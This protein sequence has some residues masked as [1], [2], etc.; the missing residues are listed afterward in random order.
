MNPQTL[1]LIV[2]LLQLGEKAFSQV[3]DI[4]HRER[5]GNPLTDEEAQA[6]KTQSDAAHATIQNWTHTP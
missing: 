1:A 5:D 4:L 6:L 3:Q 2:Q